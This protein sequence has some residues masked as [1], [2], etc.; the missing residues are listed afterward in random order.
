MKRTDKIITLIYLILGVI[1]LFAALSNS[2]AY[3]DAW[4][5]DGILPP[6]LLFIFSFAICVSFIKDVKLLTFISVIF[7]VFL[8]LV[9]CLKYSFL[10][11]VSDSVAQYGYLTNLVL[12]GR[13]PEIGYYADA[14]SGN[15]GTHISI[16]IVQIITGAP[17]EV[18][19]EYTLPLLYA[20]IPLL[21]YFI[22][23]NLFAEVRRRYIIVASALSLP[24]SY[25][26]LPRSFVL[27]FFFLFIGIFLY[28]KS[29][30][31]TGKR[32]IVLLYIIFFALMISHGATSFYFLAFLSGA[33]I[34]S[35]IYDKV[36]KKGSSR[37]KY[38]VNF[39]RLLYLLW[40]TLIFWW[41]F[42]SN[43]YFEMFTDTIKALF[44]SAQQL[45][46]TVPSRLFVIPFE[47]QIRVF[48]L[49]HIQDALLTLSA[50]I[51]A[52]MVIRKKIKV[53]DREKQIL[54][55]LF[56]MLISIFS[57]LLLQLI[58]E[59]GTLEYW[60]IFDYAIPVSLFFVGISL[61][62]IQK[63]LGFTIHKK[64]LFS[65][66]IFVLICASSISYFGYQPLMPSSRV[67]SPQLPDDEYLY[68]YR[69]VN[70]IYKISMI[71]FAE[72]NY[73]YYSEKQPRIASDKA[74]RWQIYGLTNVSFYI[75]HIYF[76]PLIE[77]DSDREWEFFLL[78]YGNRSGPLH[79]KAEY[80][81]LDRILSLRSAES[82]IYDNGEAFIL[83]RHNDN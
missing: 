74:T 59:F 57:F 7:L 19:A 32:E 77:E 14:Y 72:Q 65:F 9:T 81:T 71:N 1:L 18:V 34:V 58:F 26:L 49:V 46:E 48:T 35:K 2:K 4:I 15:P 29:G 17:L 40:I 33:F 54:M 51:G 43:L 45:K 61:F 16:G 41:M 36:I 63:R 55:Y 47:A 5:L 12:S 75:H 6:T 56:F 52:V 79:E 69:N 37:E 31:Q 82:V 25:Y 83:W 8:S 38:F 66:F 3:Q 24:V 62:Y 21:T 70:T 23:K 73:P 10:Y 44:I 67:L 20:I 80:K 39:E 42:Q 13:V 11:G 68:D 53:G 78:H 28:T 64:L 50:F 22:T 27:L 30:A 76:S 60:R